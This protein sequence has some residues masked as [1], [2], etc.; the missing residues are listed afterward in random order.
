VPATI[1]EL[2]AL[3]VK[4]LRNLNDTVEQVL[5]TCIQRPDFQRFLGAIYHEES[6]E[7]RLEY[8]DVKAVE[9]MQAVIA[10]Q[11][12]EIPAESNR[13]G[14]LVKAMR[15]VINNRYPH[16]S[17]KNRRRTANGEPV[18]IAQRGRRRRSINDDTTD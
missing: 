9:Y 4:P 15:S 6:V 14:P 17:R 2:D 8:D 16:L 18:V 1:D 7:G 10:E 12:I 13:L 5:R 3:R 11:N